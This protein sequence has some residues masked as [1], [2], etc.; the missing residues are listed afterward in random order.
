MAEATVAV[1]FPGLS[2]WALR[3][4]RQDTLASPLIGVSSLGG[5]H[6]GKTT[7]QVTLGGSVHQYLHL[8]AMALGPQQ[9]S[10]SRP[11]L[12]CFTEEPE[13][14]RTEVIVQDYEEVSGQAGLL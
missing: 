10:R 7:S 5:Q 13:V 6:S 3:C 2:F 12:L 1:I 11:T 4:G 8:D 14:R 9:P